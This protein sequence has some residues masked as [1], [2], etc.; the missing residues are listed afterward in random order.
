[1]PGSVGHLRRYLRS[2]HEVRATGAGVPETSYYPAVSRLLQDVGATL[3][4]KVRPVINIRNE[5]SG[6]PDGGLFV[7][8]SAGPVS[9]SDPMATTAPERGAIEVKPPS[10]DLA[11]VVATAQVRRYLERYGKVLVTTLRSWTLVVADSSTGK[12]KRAEA[13]EVASTEDAF[14]AVAAHPEHYADEHEAEFCDFL[15]RCMAHDAPLA[16]PRDLAWL[17]AGHA[18]TALNRVEGK[19]VAALDQLK[20][21]ISETLGLSFDDDEGERFFRSTLIQTLFYGMFS[22]WVLWHESHPD[23]DDRFSWHDAVWYLKVPMVKVLFERIA[24]PSTLG[25]LGVIEVLDWTEDLLARVDR[26]RFFAQFESASAVQYFYEPFLEH[27]DRTLRGQFGVWYTPPEVVDYMVERVDQVLRSEFGLELGLADEQ[28]VV[29]DPCV[30]TGSYLLSVLRRIAATL[31]DDALAANDVKKAAMTRIFGFEILPAPFVVAH[32][33][34]GLMLSKLGVPLDYALGERVAVYLTNALTGWSGEDPNLSLP[35]PELEKEREAAQAVKADSR[36][37]VVLGNP[38]YNPF[39]GVHSEEEVDLIEPY[40]V[41]IV[42]RNSLNDLYVRFL[43]VAERR[44]VGSGHGIVSLITNFSYLGEPG[45]VQVRRV[46]LDEFDSI[47]IDNLNGDS[48]ETG[49]RTPDG[50]PDPSVFSTRLN[51][52]GIQ[53]GTAIGT[54]VRRKTH[55]PARASVRYRDFWGETKR[56]D[57]LE[58]ARSRD[59]EAGYEPVTL[60]DVNRLAF[61]PVIYSTNYE[62][63]P[64]VVELA[65]VEPVLGLNENRGSALVDPDDAALTNRIRTYLDE[66]LSADQLQQTAAKSLMHAW[67]GHDPTGT[68]IRMQASGY[69]TAQVVRFLSRPMDLQWAYVDE[70]RTL[71]NRPRPELLAHARLPNQFLVVRRRAPRVD[72][73]AALLPASCLGDQHVLHKDAYFVPFELNI[74]ANDDGF[75]AGEESRTPNLSARAAAYLDAVG[76]E[77]SDATRTGLLWLHALA[78][79][80]SGRYLAD[81]AGG[82]AA[83]WPR[84]P[85]PATEAGL[86]A[87]AALGQQLAVLLDALQPTPS[88]IHNV[89]GRIQRTD[90]TAIQPAR[91]D[92]DVSAQWGVVQATGTVMPGRGKLVRR[93]FSEAEL[94]AFGQGTGLLVGAVDVFLNETTYWSCIPVAAWE[95]KIGGFQVLKKW[96]SYREKGAGHPSLLGRAMTPTEVREFTALAQR[97]TSVVLLGPALDAS[98]ETTI[99]ATFSWETTAAIK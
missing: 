61:R 92:L 93:E 99:A 95:F 56:E 68:R 46:L 31:P 70:T 12:A 5:G 58:T 54:F 83:D 94:T 20:L 98:Y 34:I 73:G 49:K 64:M 97:L 23:S 76:V 74:K 66:A 88:S 62:S 81:N 89:V 47:S 71:W 77:S 18:R 8:K 13:F 75:F 3:H 65:K 50:K 80:Y 35:F 26:E 16:S 78:V 15:R 72:D 10:R 91:G 53:V 59:P 1:M 84:V 40:K 44:I 39:A 63:W 96:L 6:I 9:T 25:P 21:A 7:E 86:R 38:P 57:L 48:R 28:V 36:I 11:K 29:L 52:P 45:F 2:V 87:S 30:G 42:T 19:S 37:L 55:D 67:A 33:Q 41:G 82:V 90:G 79:G 32:L 43:R 69:A 17:L 85:L 14:W 51:R 27:F 22:A 60:A 24:I 4:P